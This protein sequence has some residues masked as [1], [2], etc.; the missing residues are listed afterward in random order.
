MEEV[1]KHRASIA[2]LCKRWQIRELAVFGSAARN[3]LRP[4]SDVD[5]LVSFAPEV[6]LDLFDLIHLQDEL[7]SMLGRSVDLVERE[8]IEESDNWIVRR[9][10]L[11]SLEPVY[12]AT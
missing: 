4:D 2:E 5:I 8:A 1:L 9:E 6:E 10:V 3:E 7:E 11:G 12:A